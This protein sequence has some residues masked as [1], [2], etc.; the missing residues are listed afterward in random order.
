MEDL[1]E[2]ADAPAPGLS[3]L[4]SVTWEPGPLPHSREGEARVCQLLVSDGQRCWQGDLLRRHLGGPLGESWGDPSNLQLLKTALSGSSAAKPPAATL[5]PPTLTFGS[6]TQA[7]GWV[8]QRLSSQAPASEAVWSCSRDEDAELVLSVRFLFKEGP[9][10]A[11]RHVSLGRPL[12]AGTIQHL[13]A[14]GQGAQVAA[15]A[16]VSA[17][18]AQT[19][20][21]QRR[22]EELTKKLAELPGQLERQEQD[23]IAEFAAL[24]NAQ[25]R[26]CRRLY[27]RRQAQSGLLPER[28]HLDEE[29]LGPAT[30]TLA[31]CLDRPGAPVAEPEEDEP[32]DEGGGPRLDFSLLAELPLP[33]VSGEDRGEGFSL[34]MTLGMADFMPASLSGVKRVAASST[35][36]VARR[37]F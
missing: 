28:R 37:R 25:K 19:V 33:A 21:L 13:L 27:Q 5:A 6:Q 36:S 24:L 10:V 8:A 14:L 30:A 2:F 20:Q 3:L 1:A 4:A 15:D 31:E 35:S 7:S 12:A 11:V 29:P 18:E 26:R 22:Q 9:V 34:P 16:C 32:S 23:L 17:V